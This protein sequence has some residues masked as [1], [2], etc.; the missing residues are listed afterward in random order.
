ML[1]ILRCDHGL[2]VLFRRKNIPYVSDIYTKIFIDKIIWY[3]VF[4]SNM[5][6]VGGSTDETIWQMLDLS[7]QH[8]VH[9]II[10]STL[11][12]VWNFLQFKPKKMTYRLTYFSNFNATNNANISQGF[13]QKVILT[14]TLKCHD[15]SSDPRTLF[16]VI[17]ECNKLVA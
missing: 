12:D 14:L 11:E 5:A 7:T 16:R 6:R 2:V 13:I 17:V 8:S 1:I 4:A 10:L 15:S 9:Y 3:L